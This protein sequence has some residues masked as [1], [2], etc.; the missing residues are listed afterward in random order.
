MAVKLDKN[1]YSRPSKAFTSFNNGATIAQNA[2]NEINFCAVSSDGKLSAFSDHP[3]TIFLVDFDKP[4]TSEVYYV[5]HDKKDATLMNLRNTP[6]YE[7][8]V[9]W[10]LVE[11]K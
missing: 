7:N 10:S 6:F 3:L 5:N 4:L 9:F 1:D 2:Q 8:D 11:S